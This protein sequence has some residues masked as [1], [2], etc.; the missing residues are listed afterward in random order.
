MKKSLTLL[1]TGFM[2]FGMLNLPIHAEEVSM[3]DEV[4]NIAA[5]DND[6]QSMFV[7]LEN[8]ANLNL[9]VLDVNDDFNNMIAP[10]TIVGT[11]DRTIVTDPFAVPNHQ[12]VL[13]ESLYKT[14]SNTSI[15]NYGTGALVGEDTVLTAGHCLYSSKYGDPISVNIY[16]GFSGSSYEAKCA[17]QTTVVLPGYKKH[18]DALGDNQASANG[19]DIGLL[20]LTQKVPGTV[21]YLKTV[22]SGNADNSF[23]SYG[24]PGDKSTYSNGLIHSVSQWKSQ[25]K[26]TVT[27]DNV[28]TVDCDVWPGQSG[29]PLF[30][31]KN[32]VFAVLYAESKAK[33]EN[34]ATQITDGFIELINSTVSGRFPV[35]RVYNPNTGEHFYTAEFKEAEY[36]VGLGWISEGAAWTVG[37]SGVA[38]YRLQNPN[39]GEHHYTTNETERNALVSAG[40]KYE[41]IAWYSPASSDKPVYRLYN[42]NKTNFNHHYTVSEKE[43]NYL[44]GLG[45][46]D[47]GVAWYSY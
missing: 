36:L 10:Q 22:T 9:Q 1:L 37:T 47:E 3:S 16:V 21:G 30:N 25:G 44:V 4:F 42:P 11:D 15:A 31:S 27:T 23:V 41:N 34:Y 43:K 19:D 12:T 14:S 40:W 7:Q 5:D 2:S 26:V 39:T 33:A 28:L 13:V 6:A 46:R 17:G 20:K 35:Y 29:S 8:S 38:V 32:E 18:V 45:W 24:Y